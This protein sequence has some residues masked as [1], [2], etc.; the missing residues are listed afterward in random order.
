MAYKIAINGFGRIGRTF[1]R[2]AIDDDLEISAI[3]DLTDAKTLAHLLKYDSSYGSLVV[4]VSSNHNQIVIDGKEIQIL[5]EK[6]PLNLPWKKIGI[7]LVIESTGVFCE[8]D[9][10]SQHIEAGAKQVILTAPVKEKENDKNQIKTIVP[11]VNEDIISP[12][13]KIISMA[14][15][16]TNCLAP[17]VKVLD[18]VYGVDWVVMS[19]IHSYT[20]DQNLQDAP[21]KDLRRARSALAS[22]IPT[23]TGA[24]DSVE[25][26]IPNLKGKMAG[27]S[28]RV[29]T[30]VVS[31]VDAVVQ[32]KNQ[33]TAGEVNQAFEE[34]SNEKKYSGAIALCKESLVSID[35]KNN[36][37]AS[38]IDTQL[39]QVL[40]GNIVRVVAWY[41]NEMGY[42][43]RLVQ[44]VK[45]LEK[46]NLKEEGE[47][48]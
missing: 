5:N 9:Q 29:P 10:L 4:D 8:F 26:V 11:G 15:C 31:V 3:N 27:L 38:I 30:S 13:D 7:D 18:E 36:P 48:S 35:F 45:Y 14:S 21:H 40:N 32:V 28:F 43:N 42:S 41:D 16:T 37:N 23:T 34:A 39:T 46:R 22:I 20:M 25:K 1:L 44:L 19:T 12:N 33:T 47:N 6:D 24:T 17:V 2:S